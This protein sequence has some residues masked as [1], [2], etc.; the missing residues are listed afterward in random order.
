MRGRVGSR[1]RI[2]TGVL[3]SRGRTGGPGDRRGTASLVASLAAVLAAGAAPPAAG[4]L[5]AQATEAHPGE[6]IPAS[7]PVPAEEASRRCLELPW[8]EDPF[9]LGG[10]LVSERCEVVEGGPLI[11]VE[12]IAWSWALYRREYVYEADPGAKPETLGFFPDTVRED[13]LV[14]LV[15]VVRGSAGPGDLRPVWHDRS[16]TRSE[17]IRPPRA[18]ALPAGMVAGALFAHRRCLNGTGGCTDHPYRLTPDGSVETLRPAYRTELRARLP[19]GWGTWKGVWLDPEGPRAEAAVY[20]PSD[21]NCCPSF[22]GSATLRLTDGVLRLDSLRLSPEGGGAWRIEPGRSFGQ[23]DP[24]TSERGLIERY[25]RGAVERAAVELGEGICA[26]GS[27]VFPG[28]PWELEVGWADS[29]GERPAFAR[30]T[31]AEGPWRTPAGVRL[32]TTL[33]ELEAVRGE[34]IAFSG[35]GWDYGGTASW[36]EGGAGLRLRLAPDSASNRRL[37]GELAEAARAEELFGDRIVR[38]DH[39][40]VRRL[41]VRVVEMTLWW[42]EPSVQLDCERPDGWEGRS[43]VSRRSGEGREG[44]ARP[45]RGVTVMPRRFARLA[46]RRRY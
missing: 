6:A 25:G 39:P 31:G 32:G 8:P 24:A 46:L 21:A 23:V 4:A 3:A 15:R 22:V 30:V 17:F 16:D 7:A 1:G 33:A 28:A 37:H 29:S 27:R 10:R 41:V 26:P 45:A 20:I 43:D 38:S 34:P 13:E 14:L 12:A 11:A 44:R 36:E 5:A 2:G 19:E 18:A 35:F 9:A 40:L 42:G